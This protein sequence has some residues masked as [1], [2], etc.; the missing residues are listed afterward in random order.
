ML[1]PTRTGRACPRRISPVSAVVVVLPFVPVIAMTS[2]S[3]ARHASSSSPII[4]TPRARGP[5]S[6][7]SSS[8]TPGLTTTRS[9]PSK[10]SAGWPPVQR[11]TPGSSA[12]TPTSGARASG[13]ALSEASTRAPSR[14]ASRAAAMPLRASPT[15]A[16]VRPLSQWR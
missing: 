12:S 15:T 10:A 1:P 11:R 13:A 5:A 2:L 14:R 7:G 4:G 9:A 6:P 3:I 16:T 8:G